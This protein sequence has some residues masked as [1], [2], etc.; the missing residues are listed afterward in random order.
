MLAWALS[1][2]P[3]FAT[4]FEADFIIELMAGRRLERAWRRAGR[5]ADGWLVKHQVSLEEFCAHLGIGLD[6]LYRSRLTAKRWVDAT[7]RHVLM[8]PQLALLFPGAR[9]LHIVRDGQKCVDS[10]IHSGFNAWSARSFTLAC[11]TWVRYV[12]AGQALARIIPGRVH[13]LSYEDLVQ[14]GEN[15]HGIFEFLAEKPLAD[16]AE[17]VANKPINSSFGQSNDADGQWHERPAHGEPWNKLQH[18]VF[19]RIAG[20]LMVELGYRQDRSGV[21]NQS[22]L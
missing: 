1:E 7:P 5:R 9:F 10:M 22:E 13:T 6:H 18:L 16:C 11:M 4:S 17:F 12:R 20:S 2:H 8:S 3:A 19:N 14:N 21:V 15:W